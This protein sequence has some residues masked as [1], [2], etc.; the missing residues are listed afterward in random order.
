[1]PA[2]MD[3]HA[4]DH[5]RAVKPAAVFRP[6]LP[7]GII[8]KARHHLDIVAFALEEFAQRGAVRRDAG[9][10][11]RVVDSPDDDAHVAQSLRVRVSS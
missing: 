2:A 5:V 4:V 10:L 11:W 6:F 8:G 1:M 9:K 7:R 3:R